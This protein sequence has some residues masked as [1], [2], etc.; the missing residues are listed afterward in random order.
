MLIK[1]L[2]Y[3][4][5]RDPAT[6]VQRA[7][8][9]TMVTW[10]RAKKWSTGFVYRAKNPHALLAKSV[11]YI[12]KMHYHEAHPLR[13]YIAA[14]ETLQI[15][16]THWSKSPRN[17]ICPAHLTIKK[18]D[19]INSPFISVSAIL[20]VPAES[21]RPNATRKLGGAERHS[22]GVLKKKKK[23]VNPNKTAKKIRGAE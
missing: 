1:P 23:V 22:H 9:R 15:N 7:M 18:L 4:S 16:Q 14:A 21:G 20:S 12:M 19:E 11:R 17:K 10:D 6:S 2:P 8:R 13:H 3:Y 5:N